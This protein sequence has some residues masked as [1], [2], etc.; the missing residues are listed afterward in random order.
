MQCEYP[1]CDEEADIYVDSKYFCLHHYEN[2]TS[3]I[4][5]KAVFNY[6][7]VR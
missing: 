6:E 2:Y 4:R 5:E 7:W 1:D 3:K